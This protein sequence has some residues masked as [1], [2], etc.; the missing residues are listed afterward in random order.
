MRS[1][2]LIGLLLIFE[3][4]KAAD[5]YWVNGQGNWYDF[6]QHWATS[7]GGNIYHTSPPGPDDDVYFDANSFSNLHDT[8][9]ID[10]RTVYCRSMN[11]TGVMHEPVIYSNEIYGMT[12][13]YVYGDFVLAPNVIWK[14]YSSIYMF[15][16]GNAHVI[17]QYGVNPLV[18]PY[19]FTFYLDRPGCVWSLNS[20]FSGALVL[21]AGSLQTNGYS[22]DGY[23][24]ASGHNFPGNIG[25]VDLDTSSITGYTML[26]VTADVDSAVFSGLLSSS[27]PNHFN[28]VHVVN[29]GFTNC[30][31]E[32]LHV[33]Y[34]GGNSTTINK[35]FIE[36]NSLFVGSYDGW[37]IIDADSLFVHE[38]NLNIDRVSIN[39]ITAD[40][41]LVGPNV[42]KLT[43]QDTLF[44]NEY[45]AINGACDRMLK[46]EAEDTTTGPAVCIVPPENYSF[47]RVDFTGIKLVGAAS[48]VAVDC[49]D[50][51]ANTGIVF[52]PSS[53]R[54]VYWVGGSG[55]WNDNAHW[56][57]ASGGAGGACVPLAVD[58][59]V[60]DA[61]SFSTPSD[62]VFLDQEII[63]A[64][65]IS[66][67]QVSTPVVFQSNYYGVQF[68][69]NGSFELDT[70]VTL[71]GYFNV[72]LYS[73]DP[74]NNISLQTPLH[75][76][77]SYTGSASMI[78]HGSGI[79]NLTAPFNVGSLTLEGGT[80]NTH[81]FPVYSGMVLPDNDYAKTVQLDTSVIYG[82]LQISDSTNVN[83][84]ADSASMIGELVFS[85]ASLHLHRVNASSI[86]AYNCQFDSVD[87]HNF[88]GNGNIT[89]Y[90]RLGKYQTNSYANY[91]M[92]SGE[93]NTFS[94]LEISSLTSNFIFG[95]QG[96]YD[97]L[98]TDTLVIDTALSG[99]QM[100]SNSYLGVSDFIK[101][102]GSCSNILY[103]TGEAG[104]L[105]QMPPGSHQ[106]TR[107]VFKDA[108]FAGTVSATQSIDLGG[109]SGVAI[110][111]NPSRKLY[112]VNGGGSWNDP[113]HWSLM[114]GGA[115]GECSPTQQDSVILDQLSFSSA[116]DTLF[117]SQGTALSYMDC[118]NVVNHPVL[119]MI[120]VQ[121]VFGSVHLM[122]D[123]EY[124]LAGRIQL[125]A[126]TGVYEL[127]FAGLDLTDSSQSWISSGLENDKNA[128]W[129]LLSD[130]HIGKLRFR[131]GTLNYNSHNTY[132]SE[133]YFDSGPDTTTIN[134]GEGSIHSDYLFFGH[135]WIGSVNQVDADS[136]HLFCDQ[137]YNSLKPL[138][139]NE[140]ICTGGVETDSTTFRY[141]QAGSFQGNNNI[142]EWGDLKT[143]HVNDCYF[144][145]VRLI[146]DG[147]FTASSTHISKLNVDKNLA[148]DG[149]NFSIDSLIIGSDIR[150]FS[151]G[152]GWGG[153]GIYKYFSKSNN[154]KNFTQI[155]SAPGSVAN[156]GLPADTICLENL[157]I[158]HVNIGGGG[159]Y[160]AGNN[161]YQIGTCTGWIMSGCDLDTSSVWPGDVDDD[162]QV[163]LMD[164]LYLGIAYG[165]TGSQRPNAS[166]NWIA[167]PCINWPMVYANG[168][169]VHNADTDG[170][171]VVDDDDTLAITVN[172]GQVHQRPAP[173][174]PV[175]VSA[176]TPAF[177]VLPQGNLP[178]SSMVS[179]PMHIG[180][181]T[182]PQQDVYGM[183]VTLH[184]N[185]AAIQPGSLY[186]DALNS[187]L[188]DTAVQLKMMRCDH[189]AGIVV[190]ALVRTDHQNVSGWGEVAA[191]HFITSATGGFL[192]L[193]IADLK[194]I[195]KSEHQI[196][197][198]VMNST[199]HV[200]IQEEEN[201]GSSFIVYPNPG[202]GQIFWNEML[203]F[204]KV[205][206][207]DVYGKLCYAS[208][209]NTL[210]SHCDLSLLSNGSY[211]I[212]GKDAKGHL[213]RSNFLKISGR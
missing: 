113:Q 148:L 38:L 194:Q 103:F 179:L 174:V 80:L 43:I 48:A 212:Q 39:S 52:Q 171:G 186:M 25:F 6:S 151:L 136:A 66:G 213:F 178:L 16:S 94:Y 159:M 90:C 49:K 119:K 58:T 106:L 150:K 143:V 167:Q 120:G 89:G 29:G 169:N 91:S 162:L 123:M 60:F 102:S 166:L 193:S 110:S 30:T 54:V 84:D 50:N 184:F 1:K 161:S 204:V 124:L 134:I 83:I 42:R 175:V 88:A 192:D 209:G 98:W 21:N 116:G 121:R 195:D 63:Y 126:E 177:F 132:T 138:A 34:L 23:L 69:V 130:F 196:L 3:F 76:G 170:N 71:F 35:L 108:K 208:E 160:Y 93:H 28:V 77:T 112:W 12:N 32:E 201:F 99:F 105:F 5:Y 104:T 95:L 182:Y 9:I 27:A 147:G 2:L 122:A 18:P 153:I 14:G 183:V 137:F 13:L 97:S 57:L 157:A 190:F 70:M 20:Q 87:V 198:N 185:P 8:L 111:S 85:L 187:W 72:Q 96:P 78:I 144:Q 31:I 125:E 158:D 62:T 145:T 64:A 79:W 11:W 205:E 37:G 59:I 203:T 51:G 10:E 189:A 154:L 7:S 139:I 176:G 191:L 17:A 115:G 100:M 163:S 68:I 67:S 127:D 207:F 107:M 41:V 19:L 101:L 152:T 210:G 156:L 65:V 4:A 81:G 56:S 199:V 15:G 141:L 155:T 200:G 181:S 202:T 133:L 55:R 206:V 140:L 73:N 45:M 61:N 211:L 86:A 82:T 142:V 33:V 74:G 173:T 188:A 114:S 197:L 172:Y 40:T 109:N 36:P 22:I 44:I 46:F 118:R 24:D 53:S 168:S 128:T 135:G 75:P 47:E 149:N 131:N 146:S 129:N 164:L 165:D 180:T 92:I 117:A 26:G